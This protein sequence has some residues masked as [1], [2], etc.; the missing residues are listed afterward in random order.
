M[1]VSELITLV[2]PFY[3]PLMWDSQEENWYSDEEN[4]PPLVENVFCVFTVWQPA[5]LLVSVWPLGQ[6]YC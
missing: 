4:N 1:K 2:G 3:F 5:D 6:W